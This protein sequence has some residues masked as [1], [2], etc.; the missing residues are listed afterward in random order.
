[1][2]FVLLNIGECGTSKDANVADVRYLTKL[3]LIGCVPSGKSESVLK[4]NEMSESMFP[5]FCGVK[6][7]DIE[8][9][10]RFTHD[11]IHVMFGRILV[12]MIWCTVHLFD[13]FFFTDCREIIV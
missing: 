4:T 5:V 11:D 3:I 6:T 10:S 9:T 12:R 7:R 8:K 1:M 13:S 2:T